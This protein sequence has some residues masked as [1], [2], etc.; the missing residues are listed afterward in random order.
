MAGLFTGTGAGLRKQQR[1]KKA[2]Y[3]VLQLQHAEEERARRL[4]YAQGSAAAAA[5]PHHMAPAAGD[6][7]AATSPQPAACQSAHGPLVPAPPALSPCDMDRVQGYL[8]SRLSV[9]DLSGNPLGQ[10]GAAMVA[11]VGKDARGSALWGGQGRLRGW[12]PWQEACSKW[13]WSITSMASTSPQPA[14]KQHD[15]KDIP[16]SRSPRSTSCLLS[17]CPLHSC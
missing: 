3:A 12:T 17:T 1:A 11:Q 9:L 14:H 8:Y 16:F 4:V 15:K 7:S 2:E 6:A 13:C 10:A 5:A